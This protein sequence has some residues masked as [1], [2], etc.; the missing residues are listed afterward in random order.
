MNKR[1]FFWVK[2][3]SKER[4]VVFVEKMNN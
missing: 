4:R 2:Y 1:L 3:K